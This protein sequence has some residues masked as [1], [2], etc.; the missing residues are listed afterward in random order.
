[1][2][3]VG[4]FLGFNGGVQ[5]TEVAAP[6][7]NVHVPYAGGSACSGLAAGGSEELTTRTHEHHRRAYTLYC[8]P[9][10]SPLPSITSNLTNHTQISLTMANPQDMWKNLQKNLEKAQQQGKR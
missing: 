6:E 8:A 9:L 4:A 2:Y 3:T 1:M 7:D 10:P 5:R